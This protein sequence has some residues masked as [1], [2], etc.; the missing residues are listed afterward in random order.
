MT[1]WIGPGRRALDAVWKQLG[2][3]EQALFLRTQWKERVSQQYCLNLS[4]EDGS[5]RY[6]PTSYDP[7]WIV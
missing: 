4:R 6:C 2:Y 7:A 3:R 5:L 1:A